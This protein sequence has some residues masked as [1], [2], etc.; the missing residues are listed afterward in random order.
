MG[1][2]INRQDVCWGG[3]LLS[4]TALCLL[5]PIFSEEFAPVGS[6]E[7][8][9]RLWAGSFFSRSTFLKAGKKQPLL[10]SYVNSM[11]S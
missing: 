9:C 7:A 5:R 11:G 6:I 3:I 1:V 4:L 10:A 2:T 8:G